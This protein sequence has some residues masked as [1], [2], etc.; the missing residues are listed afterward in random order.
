MTYRQ[1]VEYLEYQLGYH[2]M[3][4]NPHAEG[5]QDLFESCPLHDSLTKQLARGIFK[6]NRCQR[7]GDPVYQ[8]KTEAVLAE[9]RNCVRKENSTDIDRYHFVEDYCRAVNEFFNAGETLANEAKPEAT[10]A[11]PSAQVIDFDR[12]RLRKLRWRA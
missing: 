3:P 9:I 5:P 10:I 4:V 7:L 6:R 2:Q 1:L 8:R 12:Y 11:R